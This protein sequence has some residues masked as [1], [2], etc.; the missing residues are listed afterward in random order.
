MCAWIVQPE[1]SL[2]LYVEFGGLRM[3]SENG[4][5]LQMAAV[6]KLNMV[7]GR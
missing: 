7:E 6:N 1:N 5:H 2:G 4:M 3:G